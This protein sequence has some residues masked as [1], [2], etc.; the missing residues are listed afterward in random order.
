MQDFLLHFTFVCVCVCVCVFAR[1]R[2]RAYVYNDYH[3]YIYLFKDVCVS[4]ICAIYYFICATVNI[5]C[6]IRR[7]QQKMRYEKQEAIRASVTQE[8]VEMCSGT[9]MTT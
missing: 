5:V 2:A 6:N 3:F 9:T 1:V 4:I 7:K 8:V